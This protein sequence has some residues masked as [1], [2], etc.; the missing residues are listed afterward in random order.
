[1][2]KAQL[3]YCV[4]RGTLCTPF[5]LTQVLSSEIWRSLLYR[6]PHSSTYRLP[7]YLSLLS[8]ELLETK[9]ALKGSHWASGSA[10]LSQGL[11]HHPSPQDDFPGPSHSIQY[12]LALLTTVE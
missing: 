12:D 8:G 2:F 5:K 3:Q 7:P 4:F 10:P 6:A 9:T 1:M 11:L